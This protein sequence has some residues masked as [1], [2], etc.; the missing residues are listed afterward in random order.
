MVD[1]IRNK[2]MTLQKAAEYM[3]V[4]V[5]TIREW[6]KEGLETVRFG[7][8]ILYTTLENL[9]RFGK[10]PESYRPQLSELERSHQEATRL[11]EEK[12]GIKT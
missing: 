3:E 2:P 7:K 8:K 6:R 1:I 10:Q 11:L 12:L 4:S 9:Q 5:K